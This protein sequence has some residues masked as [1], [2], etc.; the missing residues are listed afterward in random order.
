MGWKNVKEHY[1][2]KH[3]VHV[4]KEGI[5]I[6]SPYISELIV[7][8]LDGTIKKADVSHNKDL[9]RYCREMKSDPGTLLKLIESTDAFSKSIPVYT[10][11]DG[12]VLELFCEEIGWPNVTH[13]GQMMYDNTF[14]PSR[15]EAAL[16]GMKDAAAWIESY[17][18]GITEAKDS[19]AKAEEGIKQHNGYMRN[20]L[21]EFPGLQN[22][23]E[24]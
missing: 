11:D 15:E 6:G 7:I 1:G 14:F 17:Q 9:E 13:D 8:G 16:R 23:E 2:I 22:G 20:L 19:I 21:S 18:R 24:R 5:A 12:K 4:V 3:Q 10:Y